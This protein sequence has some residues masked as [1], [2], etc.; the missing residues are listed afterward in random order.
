MGYRLVL[1]GGDYA[2]GAVCPYARQL[3]DE[4]TDVDQTWYRHGP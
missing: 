1:Q 2:I 3:T 4:F